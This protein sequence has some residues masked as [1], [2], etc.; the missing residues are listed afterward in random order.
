MDRLDAVEAALWYAEDDDTPRNVGGVAILR[1]GDRGFDRADLVR[2]VCS[3]IGAVPR[4]RQRLRE[5]PGRLSS[6]VWVDD[7]EFDIAHHVKEASLP[8][9]GT[10]AQLEDL[11]ARLMARPVDRSRPLWEM[12]FVSGLHDGSV[13]V[14]TKSHQVLVGGHHAL[15][16]AQILLDRDPWQI[17]RAHV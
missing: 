8:M 4:Y 17:G 1:P 11:I 3:R 15:D 6:P 16:I 2:L 5:V 13:A 14:V 9:P 12:Y 7:V 10:R